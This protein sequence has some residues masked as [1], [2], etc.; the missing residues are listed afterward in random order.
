M[1]N[2]KK[3]RRTMNLTER[4]WG[5][6]T[7]ALH[8]LSEDYFRISRNESGGWDEKARAAAQELGSLTFCILFD[9]CDPGTI[10]LGK[11]PFFA[12]DQEQAE[13]E[14]RRQRFRRLKEGANPTKNPV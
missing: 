6:L 12:S 5:Q 11:F 2:T 1:A 10:P 3:I 8:R 7:L 13:Y 9:L 4:E 14:Q